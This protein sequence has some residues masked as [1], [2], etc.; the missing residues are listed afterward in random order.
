MVGLVGGFYSFFIAVIMVISG[1]FTLIF[2]LAELTSIVCFSGGCYGY[3]RCANGPFFG[4]LTACCEILANNFMTIISVYS[5]GT[6]ITTATSISRYYE[7]LWFF[8]TYLAVFLIHFQGGR[9]FWSMNGYCAI[10]GM[11]TVALFIIKALALNQYIYTEP[12]IG[13]RHVG[14]HSDNFMTMFYYPTWCLIG[15]ETATIAGA[16]ITNGSEVIPWALIY[17]VSTIAAFTFTTMM[18]SIA[19][20]QGNWDDFSNVAFPVDF[21][22][23]IV[24]N[25]DIKNMLNALL[26]IPPNFSSAV[27]F[28]FP[29]KHLLFSLSASGV[30]PAF[31]KQKWGPQQVELNS[32][33][34]ATVTQYLV[35]MI[36]WSLSL[37]PPFFFICMLGGSFLYVSVHIS[38][39]TFYFQFDS[40]KRGFHSPVGIF[41]AIY[42]IGCFSLVFLSLLIFQGPIHPPLFIGFLIVA[43]IYYFQVAQHTQFFSKEEQ[44][45]FMK[46]Y[47]V[48]ANKMRR[49]KKSKA[50]GLPSY[51]ARVFGSTMEALNSVSS[52]GTSGLNRSLSNK[53]SS[54]RVDV[55]SAGGSSSSAAAPVMDPSE[56][57]SRSNMISITRVASGSNKVAPA[58]SSTG[59]EDH[60]DVSVRPEAESEKVAE[61]EDKV[62]SLAMVAVRISPRSSFN[63]TAV[64]PSIP[65]PPASSPR[66]S[67]K[68]SDAPLRSSFSGSVRSTRDM[69]TKESQRFFEIIRTSK[70]ED[71]LVKLLEELPEHI[72]IIPEAV[73]TKDRSDLESPR[74]L[75]GFRGLLP[76]FV[77]TSTIALN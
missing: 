10:I 40:M 47:I 46:A 58:Q 26:I 42:G 43:S 9:R 56:G 31:F 41:G 61:D 18:L 53:K 11:L 69:S 36:G 70:G 49:K 33:L 64:H 24:S 45:K 7:P 52:V 65:P 1:Y 22:D 63:Q 32:L 4:Y 59:E 29:S 48:N 5:V 54:S 17:C 19:S 3:V 28:M 35:L 6:S 51:M 21:M 13:N 14:L 15:T 8:L 23:Q 57:F 12:F 20:Y 71:A 39:I 66:N 44:D 75:H 38:Y 34:T 67:S 25:Q 55:E 50:K 73:E 76:H 16:G 77:S 68:Q 2:C 37:N 60:V 27:G 62:G 30:L 72:Q 74:G